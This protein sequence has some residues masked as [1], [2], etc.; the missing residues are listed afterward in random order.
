MR[1][2]LSYRRFDHLNSVKVAILAK[3]QFAQPGHGPVYEYGLAVNEA[4]IY[5]AK[6]TAI[7]GKIAVVPHYKVRMGRNDG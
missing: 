2:V 6:V 7:V 4:I 5:R 3:K 1:F